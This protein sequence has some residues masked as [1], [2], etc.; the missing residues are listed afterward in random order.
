MQVILLERIEKLGQMGDIVTVRD[1]F[2]R[3]YLVPQGK[4]LRATKA[5]LAEFEQR[6]VQL[7]VQNLQRKEEATAAAAKI[8]GRS[9]VILRQAGEGGQLYGSVN[10]RDI[11]A[12]F[13]EIG[14]TFGRQQVRLTSPLK[15][16][17]IHQVRIA[18]HPEVDVTVEVNVAR[19]PEEA[20][21]QAHPELA[22]AAAEAEAAERAEQ[23]AA[24]A[25]EPEDEYAALGL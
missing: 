12:A 15:T 1:G 6:R 2:A 4:A 16:L 23:A 24:E 17:G 10:A 13:A 8:D 20:E 3:N 21:L 18:L 19:S 9:V 14:V 7:E 5:N 11:A 22:Q 25:P